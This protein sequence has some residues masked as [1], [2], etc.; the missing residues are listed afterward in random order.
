MSETLGRFGHHPVQVIDN[1]IEIDRLNGLLSEAHA[2]LIR[3]LDYRAATPAGLA[4]N[5][6]IRDTLRRTGFTGNLGERAEF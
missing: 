6:D 5:R 2:G 3:A 4:I 1:Q